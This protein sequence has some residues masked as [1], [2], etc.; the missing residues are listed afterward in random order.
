MPSARRLLVVAAGRVRVPA[1]DAA[2]LGE[3]LGT[4][5]GDVDGA[6]AALGDQ[7]RQTGAD[8]RRD[9]EAGAAERGGQI[10]TVDAAHRAEDRVTVGAVAVEGAIATRSITGMR[11]VSSCAPSTGAVGGRP[12]GI[13]SGSMSQTWHGTPTIVWAEPSGL[14]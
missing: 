6:R 12:V 7:L 10:E 4:E 9:L 2:A 3:A 14:K 8:G 13:V 5:R 11:C 1:R